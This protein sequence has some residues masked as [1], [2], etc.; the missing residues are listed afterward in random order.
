M[1]KNLLRKMKNEETSYVDF[2]R[3]EYSRDFSSLQ[4]SGV[5]VTPE[6]AKKYLCNAG[7]CE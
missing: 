7:R 5:K 2:M 6:L 1:F 3:V 4:K